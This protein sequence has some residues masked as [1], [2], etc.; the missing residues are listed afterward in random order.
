M[1]KN[2]IA[3]NQI[4]NEDW[5]D[6]KVLCSPWTETSNSNFLK[7]TV[8][9][10]ESSGSKICSFVNKLLA[11]TRKGFVRSAQNRQMTIPDYHGM[12]Q[13]ENALKKGSTLM[14]MLTIPDVCLDILDCNLE[15]RRLSSLNSRNSQPQ[16]QAISRRRE[17]LLKK[18]ATSCSFLGLNLVSTALG[19]YGGPTAQF[20][21]QLLG[22][23]GVLLG[24]YYALNKLKCAVRE[25]SELKGEDAKTEMLANRYLPTLNLNLKGP[26]EELLKTRNFTIK[27]KKSHNRFKFAVSLIGLTSA[28][29]SLTICAIHIAGSLGFLAAGVAVSPL[30][31]AALALAGIALAALASRHIYLNRSN[32]KMNVKQMVQDWQVSYQNTAQKSL[33]KRLLQLRQRAELIQVSDARK[34][35]K[36]EDKLQQIEAKINK[37]QSA[38]QTLDAKRVQLVFQKTFGKTTDPNRMRI[39]KDAALAL[40][41]QPEGREFLQ[42]FFQAFGGSLSSLDSNLNPTPGAALSWF[43]SLPDESE[44]RSQVVASADANDDRDDIAIPREIDREKLFAAHRAYLE[45]KKRENFLEE[46]K[47]LFIPII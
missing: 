5:Q 44:I 6:L 22:S 46:F 4:S 26:A 29:I 17:N 28:L 25:R 20:A 9:T 7:K 21:G 40:R 18:L 16:L 45:A 23:V 1:S 19:V 15:I 24:P 38:Q 8:R 11:E 42:Q 37:L 47:G 12:R 10:W 32:W 13:I 30:N 2:T 33:E 34:Q 41:G 3:L 36:I 39:L 35:Q 31:I 14:G 43:N 27:N